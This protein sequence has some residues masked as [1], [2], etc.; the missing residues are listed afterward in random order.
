MLPRDRSFELASS[1]RVAEDGRRAPARIAVLQYD[2][3]LGGA[4]RVGI[5]L[6]EEFARRGLAVDLV[7]TRGTGPLM[8]RVSREVR[9]VDIGARHEGDV[10]WRLRRYVRGARPGGILSIGLLANL[11][12]MMALTG[13]AQ[14]PRTVLT[15]H[16]PYRMVRRHMPAAQGFVLH[17]LSRWLYR[18]ADRVVG[19][20]RGVSNDLELGLGLA[21]GSVETIYNPVIGACFETEAAAQAE[22]LAEPGQDEKLIVTVGRL[23]P[24][25]DLATLLRAFAAVRAHLPARLA[26][27]GDGYQRAGLEALARSLGVAD[28]VQFVGYVGNPYP[29]MKRADLFVLSSMMEGFGNVLVEAMAA[30]TPIVSTRTHGPVEILEDGRWGRLVAPGDPSALAAAML[31]TLDDGGIDARERAAA[32]AVPRIADQYLELL[33][34][35]APAGRAGAARPAQGQAR[36]LR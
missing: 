2:A 32:F 14:R 22:G 35:T 28:K 3:G 9:V 15:V 19:V 20:S 30:G 8:S 26:V 7:L 10:P 31:E 27:V 24:Q 13:L 23:V 34:T 36:A 17:H 21:R 16:N 29:H 18:G 11:F 12:T 33:L 6:A 25:K 5:T 1:A 4:Q